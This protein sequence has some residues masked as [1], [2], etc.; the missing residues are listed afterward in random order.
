MRKCMEHLDAIYVACSPT[1]LRKNVDGLSILVKQSFGLDPF[2]RCLFLFCNGPRNRLKG[3]IWAR[4]G[5]IMLYKRLDGVGARFVWPSDRFFPKLVE[6]LPLIPS[7]HFLSEKFKAAS[8]VHNSFDYFKLIDAAFG[9][10]II[11]IENNSIFNSLQILLKAVKK[12]V[13]VCYGKCPNLIHPC[14]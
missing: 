12:G 8:A 10:T 5:F 13:E 9:Q 1:D 4:N 11:T 7:N 14:E 3:L 6:M 2:S